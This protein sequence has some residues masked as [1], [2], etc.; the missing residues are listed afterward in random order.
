MTKISNDT[1][2]YIILI[3]LVASIAGLPPFGGF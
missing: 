1:R 2:T 3:I